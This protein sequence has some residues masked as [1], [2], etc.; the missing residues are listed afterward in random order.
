[1]YINHY[2][3]TVKIERSCHNEWTF[4]NEKTECTYFI[5]LKLYPFL[6]ENDILDLKK[7]ASVNIMTEKRFPMKIYLKLQIYLAGCIESWI[8]I[9]SL[10]LI[11]TGV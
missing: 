9:V 6:Y 5:K 3:Y 2:L 4:S 10:D 11:K 7:V 8:L 1:M